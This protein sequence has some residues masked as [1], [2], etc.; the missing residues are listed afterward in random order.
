MK[1]IKA[2]ILL[3]ILLFSSCKKNEGKGGSSA[4][5]GVLTT[6]VYN[7]SDSLI[8]KYPKANEDLFIIYGEGNTFYNDKISTSYDGSFKF[9]YLEKGKYTIY[10]YEDCATCP[11][12][13]QVVLIPAEISKNKSTLELGELNVKKISNKGTSS[14]EGSIFVKNYNSTGTFINEGPGA[15]IDVYIIYNDN[16]TYSDR[17]R[18]NNNGDFSFPNLANGHYTIYA[19]SDCPS[20]PDGLQA[21]LSSVNITT[22][23]EIVNTGTITINQ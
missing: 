1:A 16:L 6:N 4:I 20:C 9:D 15:D 18:S 5:T 14:I 17:I 13:E 8:G 2:I 11:E 12:E 23:N 10:Y 19:Y 21:V 3:T 22:Q 7:N